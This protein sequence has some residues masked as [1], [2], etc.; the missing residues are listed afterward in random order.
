MGLRLF[1]LPNFPGA[2][3]IQGATFIPDSRVPRR[4][5]IMNCGKKNPDMLILVLYAIVNCGKNF[6]DILILVLTTRH[7]ERLHEFLFEPKH[8]LFS[9]QWV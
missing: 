5:A 8:F 1:F 2:T 3:F 4:Y 9:T 7:T 6:L